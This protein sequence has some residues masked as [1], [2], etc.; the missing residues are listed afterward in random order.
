[1]NVVSFELPSSAYWNHATYGVNGML[2]SLTV[3]FSSIFFEN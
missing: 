3:I 2:D 1:M